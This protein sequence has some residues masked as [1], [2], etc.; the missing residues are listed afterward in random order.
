M[1]D[2]KLIDNGYEIDP[3]DKQELRGRRRVIFAIKMTPN[4]ERRA[5]VGTQLALAFEPRPRPKPQQHAMPPTIQELNEAIEYFVDLGMI[6]NMHGDQ[7]HYTQILPS[8]QPASS[9]STSCGRTRRGKVFSKFPFCVFLRE[10]R[11]SVVL[12]PETNTNPNTMT[13]FTDLLKNA[14]FVKAE[15][16]DYEMQIAQGHPAAQDIAEWIKKEYNYEVA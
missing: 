9:A 3:A 6:A 10:S 14:S 5:T 15:Y 11:K 12:V 1:K 13:S 16:A 8:T 7:R 4:T 2:G